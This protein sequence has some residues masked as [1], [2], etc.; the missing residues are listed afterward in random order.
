MNYI[1]AMLSHEDIQQIGTVI[2]DRL[3]PVTER[4]DGVEQRLI[5]V[6]QRIDASE[7]R[8]GAKIDAMD[9]KLD[10]AQE[11][12]AAILTTVIDHHTALEQ[13]VTRVASFEAGVHPKITS[14]RS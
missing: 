12:I 8:L 3:M 2:R 4:L 10:Q 9:R 6:G 5:G 7:A 1:G 13:R 14:C 11:D